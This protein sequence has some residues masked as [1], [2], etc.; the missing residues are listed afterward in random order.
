MPK[1]LYLREGIYWAR[2]KIKGVE[3]RESLRT[4][5]ERVAEKRMKALRESVEDEAV[6]GIDGPVTWPAAVVSWNE[7]IA[8]AIGARTFSRYASSLKKMRAFLDQ[9]NVQTITA[10]FLK[11]MIKSRKRSGVKNATIRRDLTALSSVFN[12]AIDEGWISDNPATAINR[13]RIVPEKIVKIV[14][15][16]PESIA[17][18]FPKLPERIRD[19][20]EFTRE[21]GLRMD[22][23]IKLRH[24]DVERSGR[25][26]TV[27][28]GK[29]SKVRT[30]PL[31]AQAETII[32]RQPRYIG[33]PWVFW[34]N[35]GDPFADVSSRIGGYVS[36]AAQKA[37]REER[38]FLPF[39]H[40]GF[41]HLFAVEYL[42]LSRGSIYDL[43]GEMGHDS[44]ST[45]E[46]Y[47]AFLTPE[48]E[49]AAR[50]GVAQKAAQEQRF[51]SADQ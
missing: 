46:R 24:T 45:T 26:I 6:Y 42:R 35:A 44:I 2:F 11:D 48:Q 21:T 12:H 5:S 37:A 3:Y 28:N 13:K 7:S 19:M 34:K 36:R 17:E 32:D 8:D 41:R 30:I 31:T 4:R 10:D 25:F 9:H 1:N 22:E 39:S 29:G 20:C 50:H 33:K 40:H 16:Q 51:G 47:L 38:E 49:K 23:L 43:Q 18:I 27:T 15:P 14:L